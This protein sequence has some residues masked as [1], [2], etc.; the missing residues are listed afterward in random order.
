MKID[1]ANIPMSPKIEHLIHNL[2][3]QKLM[4]WR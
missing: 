3:K 1:E 4:K 2:N